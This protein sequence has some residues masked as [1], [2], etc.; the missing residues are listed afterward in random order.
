ML[1][2]GDIT[3][4]TPT[5]SASK[6]TESNTE[7]TKIKL[8]FFFASFLFSS[9]SACGRDIKTNPTMILLCQGQFRFIK[10]KSL[11]HVYNAKIDF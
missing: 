2:V 7:L 5:P 6:R 8:L 10:S 9:S 3:E 11:I 1:K 4:E